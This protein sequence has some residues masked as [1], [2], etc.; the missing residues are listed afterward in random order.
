MKSKRKPLT[1]FLLETIFLLLSPVAVLAADATLFFSPVTGVFNTGDPIVVRVMVSSENAPINAVE[2]VFRYDPKEVEIISFDRSASFLSSWTQEPTVDQEKGEVVF[3]GAMS[4]TSSFSGVRGEVFALTMKGLRSE[5][6]R[7]DFGSGSASAIRAADGTGGNLLSA[8]SSGVYIFA[9]REARNDETFPEAVASDVSLGEVLGVATGTLV[10]SSETHPDQDAWYGRSSATIKWEMPEDVSGVRLLLDRRPTGNGLVYYAAPRSTRE[11]EDIPDGI[12]YVHLTR[13]WES[14]ETD[15]SHYRLQIDTE[16]PQNVTVSEVPREDPTDPSPFFAVTATDT[17]S[18]VSRY[19]FVF[20]GGEPLSWVDD[21]VGAF[22][23][24]IL[25][26]GAHTLVVAAIDRAGNRAT[27]QVSF[28][29]EAIPAPVLDLKDAERSREGDPLR[30]SVS[31]IP[32]STV[33]FSVGKEGDSPASE[34]LVLDDSGVGVFQS[35]LVPGPGR[36]T[37]SAIAR[38]A[39]GAESL[40]SEEIQVVVRASFFG[41][42]KRNPFI[43]AALFGLL[44]MLVAGWFVMRRVRSRDNTH[45][46]AS[47]PDTLEADGEGLNEKEEVVNPSRFARPVTSSGVVVLGGAKDRKRIL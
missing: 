1:F 2:G 27:A 13:E 6:T 45:H 24:P 46:E 33:Y 9:P 43:P 4:G 37:I 12:W 40:Q 7:L 11:I 31:A 21:G 19:E 38:K 47:Y 26:P 10:L 22:R 5:E 15:L 35:A 17:L 25:P 42:V 8:L 28:A 23:A 16:P 18:G 36:Y 3:A 39:N 32:S 30:V 34:Q 20:D 41:M 14:G 29:I 44:A